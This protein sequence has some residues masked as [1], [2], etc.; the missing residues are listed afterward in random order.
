MLKL[1]SK[2]DLVV[3]LCLDWIGKLNWVIWFWLLLRSWRDWRKWNFSSCFFKTFFL[4]EWSVTLFHQFDIYFNFQK[5]KCKHDE[6]KSDWVF[7]SF[8]FPILL[9]K[10]LNF[11]FSTAKRVFRGRREMKELKQCWTHWDLSA[12]T[13]K[14]EKNLPRMEICALEM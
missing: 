1:A 2:L 12:L 14:K 11:S 5:K 9:K 10:W 13:N 7:A 8:V 6:C 4:N 3:S